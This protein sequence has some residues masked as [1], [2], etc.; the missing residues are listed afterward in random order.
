MSEK[1]SKNSSGE[2]ITTDDKNLLGLSVTPLDRPVNRM[3]LVMAIFAVICVAALYIL[4]RFEPNAN[5]GSIA[6]V[7]LIAFVLTG[8]IVCFYSIHKQ[9]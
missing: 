9:K 4:S 1:L 5:H 8:L 6:I 2:P 3:R 7:F